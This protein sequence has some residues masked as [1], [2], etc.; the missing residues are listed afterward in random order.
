M[1]IPVGD[2]WRNMFGVGSTADVPTRAVLDG[3]DI[4]GGIPNFIDAL[5]TGLPQPVVA[6]D[7]QNQVVALNTPA[8][9]ILPALRRGEPVS[10]G[11]RVPDVLDAIRRAIASGIPQRVEFAERVPFER[12]Y[13]A[14]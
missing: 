6:L 12:W 5:L 11:L 14:I 10:L 9:A 13:E 1:A 4:P 8:A 2:W 7:H 3:R